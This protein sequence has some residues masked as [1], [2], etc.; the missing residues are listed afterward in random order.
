MAYSIVPYKTAWCMISVVWPFALLFGCAVD[1]IRQRA[2]FAT[3]AWFYAGLLL[4]GS[5]TV[6]V[7]LNFFHPTDAKEPYVYVQTVPEMAVLTDPLLGMAARD[8]RNYGLGGEILLESYFPIPWVIGEFP[9]IGYYDKPEKIPKVLE[10]DFIVALS[11]KQDLVQGEIKEPYL[12]MRFH[13]R[14]SMDECSV[15]FK[16]RVFKDWFAAPGH[17]TPEVVKPKSKGAEPGKAKK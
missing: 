8:P 15:W 13:L 5:L 1:E 12:R 9:R 7:R 14:D 4:L 11:E 6:C 10:G 16:E 2:A 3:L 17:G